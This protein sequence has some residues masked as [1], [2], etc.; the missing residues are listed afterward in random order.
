MLH[1][2]RRM[3]FAAREEVAKQLNKMR[4]IV[5]KP[6]RSPWPSPVV[7]VRKNDSSH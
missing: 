6:S 1:L 3:P 5:V 4:Q 2:L 7:L